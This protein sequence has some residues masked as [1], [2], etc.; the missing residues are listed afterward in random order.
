MSPSTGRSTSSSREKPGQ[1]LG[2]VVRE[3]D[4]A[5]GVRH[6]Q[7]FRGGLQQRAPRLDETG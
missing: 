3:D 6:Y 1:R 5:V 2:V 4:P 7:A